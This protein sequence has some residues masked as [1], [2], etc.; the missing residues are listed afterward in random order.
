MF[1]WA[2]QFIREHTHWTYLLVIVW[3]F[4]E[5][6]TIVIVCGAFAAHAGG[7]NAVGIM[8][9]ALAGSMAG[10]QTWFYVGRLKGKS[11]I[12]RRPWLQARADKVHR[13]LEQWHTLLILVFR[14]LYGL[15]NITPFVLGMSD[16]KSRRFL[17]LNFI[18][19]AVWAFVF[20]YG[21]YVF[22]KAFKTYLHDHYGKALIALCALVFLIWLTRFLIRLRRTRKG[23][24]AARAAAAADLARLPVRTPPTTEPPSYA[25]PPER[26]P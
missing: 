1:E 18:G 25:A 14:F 13:L 17:I 23:L 15:R 10:D 2:E 16:L 5:G 3:T 7:P 8:L 9:S 21:G 4:L 22:G 24:A 26:M 6:E 12:V 11:F 20:T 19:A